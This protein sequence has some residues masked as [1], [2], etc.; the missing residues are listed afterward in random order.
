MPQR[1]PCSAISADGEIDKTI[2]PELQRPA[3]KTY[4]RKQDVIPMYNHVLVD[5][6]KKQLDLEISRPDVTLKS[7]KKSTLKDFSW[8]SEL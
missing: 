5:E 6:P 4:V 8:V 1:L 3:K 7:D 2:H